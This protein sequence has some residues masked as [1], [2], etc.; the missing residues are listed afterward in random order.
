MIPKL[1]IV[2]L[3]GILPT[4]NYSE[5]ISRHFRE[6]MESSGMIRT[7]ISIMEI[8]EHNYLL[9]DD[10][11]ILKAANDLKIKYLP[12]QL[13]HP[14]QTID[15]RAE[16]LV[17]DFE[18][19]FM[20]EFLQI[21]PRVAKICTDKK[22]LRNYKKYARLELT[23]YGHKD[24][25]IC[26]HKNDPDR[27][28]GAIFDFLDFLGRKSQLIRKIISKRIRAANIKAH[29]NYWTI[30]LPELTL[31]Q[32]IDSARNQHYFPPGFIRFD[33]GG[34]LIGVEYPIAILNEKVSIREKERFLY[35]LINYRLNNGYA[36]YIEGG[37]YLLNYLVKK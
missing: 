24:A 17:R 3:S 27:L 12:A 5:E 36:E 16:I 34:R 7:P 4:M 6:M 8:S 13:A 15:I 32:I 28:P 29:Q 22:D 19:T 31:E 37:V 20:D 33:F 25:A 11:A 2:P 30:R 18:L 21:F 9:F 35:D 10:S 1:K 23:H 26:F 14:N